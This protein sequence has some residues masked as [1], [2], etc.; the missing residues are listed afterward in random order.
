MMNDKTIKIEK[1]GIIIGL[2][3]DLR[4]LDKDVRQLDKNSDVKIKYSG[5]DITSN[6]S[7][8]WLDRM[9]LIHAMAGIDVTS[10]KY[11]KGLDYAVKDY[12]DDITNSR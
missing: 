5:G 8:K 1:Y 11:I 9:I 12:D 2:L 10:E 4:Q 6:W 3:I 7:Y